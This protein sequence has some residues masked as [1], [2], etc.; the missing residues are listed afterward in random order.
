MS[1]S[2]SSR[3]QATRPWIIV[4]LASAIGALALLAFV[5]HSGPR[6]ELGQAGK[7]PARTSTMT[8]TVSSS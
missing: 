2:E 7:P 3:S 4:T 6:H 5:I 8:S 1:S